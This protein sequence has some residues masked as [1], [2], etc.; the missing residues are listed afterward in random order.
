MIALDN[1]I[2]DLQRVGGVSKVWA[3][4]IQNLDKRSNRIKFL[5]SRKAKQNIF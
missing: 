2:F 5:E 1:L 4:I 3:K